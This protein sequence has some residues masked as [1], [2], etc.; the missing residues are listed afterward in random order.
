MDTAYAAVDI[1]GDGSTVF[2]VAL[3]VE[4][5]VVSTTVAG[6]VTINA[7]MK[8]IPT[9]GGPVHIASGAPNG[10]IFRHAGDEFGIVSWPDAGA[11]IPRPGDRIRVV[12]GHCDTTCNLYADL[13]VIKEDGLVE[14]WPITARGRW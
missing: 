3:F 9:D 12:T 2:E 14:V 7:G 1:A 13:H 5:E 8:A 4:A 11:Q 10:S 6:Q